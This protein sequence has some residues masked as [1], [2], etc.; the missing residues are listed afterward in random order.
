M[1]IPTTFNRHY[2]FAQRDWS[3]VFPWD[4]TKLALPKM[5]LDE[6]IPKGDGVDLF[7]DDITKIIDE[8]DLVPA[9]F[10]PHYGEQKTLRYKL[11]PNPPTGWPDISPGFPFNFTTFGTQNTARIG[12]LFQVRN[13]PSGAIDLQR[14]NRRVHKLEFGVSTTFAMNIQATQFG[15]KTV[16]FNYEGYWRNFSGAST[17]GHPNAYWEEADTPPTLHRLSQKGHRD[18]HRAFAP[19]DWVETKNEL[20]GDPSDNLGNST[21]PLKDYLQDWLDEVIALIDTTTLD[22]TWRLAGIGWG[23]PTTIGNRTFITQSSAGDRY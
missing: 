9:V 5:V 21:T 20:G 4:V 17:P 15:G 22:A 6:E 16:W 18:Y 11:D 23:L 19:G 7:G 8:P 1:S 3:F 12:F 10:P 2:P 13:Q 14:P